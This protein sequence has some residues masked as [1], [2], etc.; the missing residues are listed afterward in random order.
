MKFSWL[1][2]I[3]QKCPKKNITG[4]SKFDTF[5]Y[6]VMMKICILYFVFWNTLYILYV[7]VCNYDN[8]VH[9]YRNKHHQLQWGQNQNTIILRLFIWHGWVGVMIEKITTS[10]K[11]PGQMGN[12]WT[13]ALNVIQQISL[14]CQ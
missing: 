8:K 5:I 14:P 3:S 1:S 10:Y 12:C 2:N 6:V 13:T 9:S 11:N 4:D 7:Q